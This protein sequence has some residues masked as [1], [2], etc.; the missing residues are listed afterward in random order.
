MVFERAFPDHYN[1]QQADVDKVVTQAKQK[2]ARSILTTA[3]D[4]VKLTSLQFDIPCY[5]LEI[6]ISIAEEADLLQ[7][8]Q[9]QLS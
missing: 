8:I 5:V 3:K 6:E 9:N 1:Y 2:G 4:A 7:L